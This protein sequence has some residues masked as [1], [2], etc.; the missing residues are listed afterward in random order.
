MRLRS[1]RGV[2][3][4]PESV[5]ANTSLELGGEDED[6]AEDVGSQDQA[7]NTHSVTECCNNRASG[8]VSSASTN[9]GIASVSCQMAR[10]N[11]WH[12]KGT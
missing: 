1:D 6:G 3:A 2:D 4:M 9:C 5:G 12:T 10:H 11:R 8:S 7:R